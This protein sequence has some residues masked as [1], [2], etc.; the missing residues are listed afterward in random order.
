MALR[1][2]VAAHH[3][4][5]HHRLPSLVRKAGMM[6]WKGR[7]PGAT[8]LGWPRQ[9]EAVAAVLQRDAVARHHHARAEAH[10]VALD[11]ADHH[12]A[13]VG[14]GQV[15]GAA[16]DRVAG[17]EVLRAPAVDQLRALAR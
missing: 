16:L 11:E 2:H 15:D 13:L 4:E 1:L 7:L 17:A 14:R 9:A 10:V 8:T 3:A 12:A 6:V 5:A